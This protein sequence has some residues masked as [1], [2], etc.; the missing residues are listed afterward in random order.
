MNVNMSYHDYKRMCEDAAP[1]YAVLFGIGL[2]AV[3]YEKIDDYL[4]ERKHKKEIEKKNKEQYEKLCVED[5]AN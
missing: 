2:A 5:A 1:F 4:W 3:V